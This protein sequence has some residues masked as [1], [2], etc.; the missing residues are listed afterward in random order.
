MG[1]AGLVGLSSAGVAW[2]TEAVPPALPEEGM[3]WLLLK[4]LVV[5]GIVV[6]LVYLSLNVGLRKLM[7]IK[8]LSPGMYRTVTV[9][10]RIPLDPRRTLFL[11]KV[12]EE[13]LLLGGGENSVNLLTHLDR[14]KLEAFLKAAGPPSVTLSPFL[15]KL[16]SRESGAPPSDA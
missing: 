4:T 2:A 16:L 13:Y 7:G 3:G 15:K 1:V 10:E 5:L 11:V 8:G 14:E 12:A 9:L 6:A